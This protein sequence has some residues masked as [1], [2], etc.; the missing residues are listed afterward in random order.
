ML[1]LVCDHQHNFASVA[2]D[3]RPTKYF[4]KQKSEKFKIFDFQP[5]QQRNKFQPYETVLG[6]QE[7]FT[8][9][10]KYAFLAQI[11]YIKCV[12]KKSRLG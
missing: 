7:D 3:Q 5:V 6:L 2:A 11:H 8:W 12:Q 9:V 4:A 1:V 10:S